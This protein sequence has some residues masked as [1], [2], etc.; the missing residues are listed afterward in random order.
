MPG[1]IVVCFFLAVSRS[2]V[3]VAGLADES[4]QATFTSLDVLLIWICV[5]DFSLNGIGTYG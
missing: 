5:K 2:R 3:L 1:N 4:L